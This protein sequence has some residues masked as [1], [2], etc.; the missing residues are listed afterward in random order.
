M[1]A[2]PNAW[3]EDFRKGFWSHCEGCNEWGWNL[4]T[5]GSAKHD[6]PDE[7]IGLTM[8]EVTGF[9]F[10]AGVYCW[11]CDKWLGALDDVLAQ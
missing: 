10:E 3:A 9:Y 5:S 8:Q 1:Q 4:Y 2:D 7:A 6:T 11:C